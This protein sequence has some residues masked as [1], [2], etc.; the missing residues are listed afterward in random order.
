MENQIAFDT[1]T[2]VFLFDAD[3]KTFKAI[4]VLSMGKH[5][6]ILFCFCRI[7]SVQESIWGTC[8]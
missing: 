6:L 3:I 7:P 5:F 2:Y 8:C 1:E 4:I